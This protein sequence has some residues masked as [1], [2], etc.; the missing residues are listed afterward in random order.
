MSQNTLQYRRVI[1]ETLRSTH[2][3]TTVLSTETA[4]EPFSVDGSGNDSRVERPGSCTGSVKIRGPHV[5]QDET[6]G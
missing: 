3:L 5:E 1:S 2:L 4:M 6:P